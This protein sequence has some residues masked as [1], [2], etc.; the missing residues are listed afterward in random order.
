MLGGCRCFTSYLREFGGLVN[1]KYSFYVLSLPR[2]LLVY[3]L[4]IVESD[5]CLDQSVVGRLLNAMREGPITS[6]V[7][8][9][10]SP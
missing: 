8:D 3:G 4:L 7:S 6:S 2:M 10:I 9:P 5:S 1:A